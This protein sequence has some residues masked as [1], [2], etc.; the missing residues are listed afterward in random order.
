MVRDISQLHRTA[1]IGRSKVA[2]VHFGSSIGAF[3]KSAL[4]GGAVAWEVLVGTG[5]Q[6]K[7]S[8]PCLVIHEL[9][10]AHD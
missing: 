7:R 1:E 9:G 2:R 4:R 6:S 8:Q 10:D 3:F 5:G